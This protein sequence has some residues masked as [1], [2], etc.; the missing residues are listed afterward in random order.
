MVG[1]NEARS[2][3]QKHVCVRAQVLLYVAMRTLVLLMLI[4][5]VPLSLSLSSPS[6]SFKKDV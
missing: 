5:G 4:Y 3:V 2:I 6:L 1:G